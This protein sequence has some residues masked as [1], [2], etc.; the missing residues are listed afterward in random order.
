[1]CLELSWCVLKTVEL[2]GSLTMR[3]MRI[4]Q[5]SMSNSHV[6]PGSEL[7]IDSMR[8]S[9]SW[10]VKLISK[11]KHCLFFCHKHTVSSASQ[12]SC[13]LHCTHTTF[14]FRSSV[15][16]SS[17]TLQS[18]LTVSYPCRSVHVPNRSLVVLMLALVA[19]I[20]AASKTPMTFVSSLPTSSHYAILLCAP[21][22]DNQAMSIIR[23]PPS[24]QSSPL[25]FEG[26]EH[27]CRDYDLLCFVVQSPWGSSRQHSPIQMDPAPTGSSF[28]LAPLPNSTHNNRGQS[29]QL[30]TIRTWQ[31]LA[32][33]H[34]L[35]LQLIPCLHT[36]STALMEGTVTI[37]LEVI[38]L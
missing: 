35:L 8:R 11:K 7:C 31:A 28:L 14:V 32:I 12:S 24:V 3:T 26:T 4:N 23:L 37:S 19:Q 15:F 22:V 38:G 17:S 29:V 25:S 13:L 10:D 36:H 5:Y 16:P 30:Q 9:A 20:T 21:N 18:Y 2:E 6:S 34:K 33:S 1:M 27:D